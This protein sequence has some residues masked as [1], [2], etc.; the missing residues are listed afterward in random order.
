MIGK[1]SAYL[2]ANGHFFLDGAPA[3]PISPAPA[4]HVT[5]A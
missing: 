3:K 2:C 1:D 4:D 5:S